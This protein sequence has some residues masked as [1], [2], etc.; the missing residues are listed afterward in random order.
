MGIA[1][2]A[3]VMDVDDLHMMGGKCVV[4]CVWGNSMVASYLLQVARE[5]VGKIH[6]FLGPMGA[7]EHLVYSEMVFH[8]KVSG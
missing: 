5:K 7:E 2:A 3:M 8:T 1:M 4:V 6:G